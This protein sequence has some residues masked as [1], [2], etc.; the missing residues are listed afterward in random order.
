[1]KED[2]TV[3]G[4]IIGVHTRKRTFA[5]ISVDDDEIFGKIDKT[6]EDFTFE[7]PKYVEAHLEKRIE[8]NAASGKEKRKYTLFG[9]VSS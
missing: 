3:R 1:M 5:F 8:V 4:T 6:L 7:V 2:I 9:R